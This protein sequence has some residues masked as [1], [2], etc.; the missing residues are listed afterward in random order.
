MSKQASRPTRKAR[1]PKHLTFSAESAARNV[2]LNTN[3]SVELDEYAVPT[4]QNRGAYAMT[5]RLFN[6][7]DPQ[8]SAVRLG[9]AIND[10]MWDPEHS[11]ART[12]EGEESEANARMNETEMR[13]LYGDGWVN[14]IIRRDDAEATYREVAAAAKQAG[15]LELRELDR[16]YR[17]QWGRL[18]KNIKAY[19]NIETRK[20]RTLNITRNN[21]IKRRTAIHAARNAAMAKIPSEE[22]ATYEG[23][24]AKIEAAYRD[25]EAAA[26][27]EFQKA[28][29]VGLLPLNQQRAFTYRQATRGTLAN[30]LSAAAARA[31]DASKK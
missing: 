31:A 24:I 5:H 11:A 3:G 29:D 30:R 4:K 16:K 27:V 1:K 26:E 17:A 7:S 14:A 6:A 2:W 8:S 21:H 20:L 10:H 15:Q 22:L 23:E 19:V 12:Y 13:T 28:T 9:R 18:P 25:K